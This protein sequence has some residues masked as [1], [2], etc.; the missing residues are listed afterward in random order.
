MSGTIPLVVHGLGLEP[1]N[2]V[3]AGMLPG[4]AAG[5]CPGGGR[6]QR[7]G[8]GRRR[9]A[10]ARPR[11]RGSGNTAYDAYASGMADLM[12]ACTGVAV[13]GAF[14]VALLLPARA[15]VTSGVEAPADEASP[16]TTAA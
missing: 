4:R 9:P 16:G 8:R 5:P 7:G 14:L 10:P 11:G 3:G 6:G 13:V 1:S 12:L 2:A 15:A